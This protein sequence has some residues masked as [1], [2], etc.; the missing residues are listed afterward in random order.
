MPLQLFSHEPQ[1]ACSICKND[2]GIF[3]PQSLTNR[4]ACFNFNPHAEDFNPRTVV[5][6]SAETI[7]ST[8]AV[9]KLTVLEQKFPSL[10]FINANYPVFYGDDALLRRQAGNEIVAS[11]YMCNLNIFNTGL[12]LSPNDL[13]IIAEKFNGLMIFSTAPGSTGYTLWHSQCFMR[14]FNTEPQFLNNAIF[15]W[16]TSTQIFQE[17]RRRQLPVT[18]TSITRRAA[19]A[20]QLSVPPATAT[21]FSGPLCAYADCQAVEPILNSA[22]VYNFFYENSISDAKGSAAIAEANQC[23]PASICSIFPGFKFTEDNANPHCTFI[24]YSAS[25]DLY[26]ETFQGWTKNFA[27]LLVYS[28]TSQRSRLWHATCLEEAVRKHIESRVDNSQP[29]YCLEDDTIIFY[30][31]SP[32]VAISRTLSPPSNYNPFATATVSPISSAPRLMV[33]REV[34]QQKR[35]TLRERRQLGCLYCGEYVSTE[36][37]HISETKHIYSPNAETN[38]AFARF[39]TVYQEYTNIF[40]LYG[41]NDPTKYEFHYA[42]PVNFNACRGNVGID[43]LGDVIESQ[44]IDF[45]K[46]AEPVH[47]IILGILTDAQGSRLVGIHV[48]CSQAH[49]TP[50]SSRRFTQLFRL[51]KKGYS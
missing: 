24:T 1:H 21:L 2:S 49:V 38:N 45:L 40:N 7:R 31:D 43:Q 39:I 35:R 47:D 42:K 36:F 17:K 46:K 16:F 18:P 5:P 34:A 27:H 14:A 30:F 13:E 26:L 37:V 29:S 28:A 23:F 48:R 15:F 8:L 12:E 41:W 9:A 11:Q 6:R 3:I 4:F 33:K 20:P 10:Q 44:L 51:F 32:E 25:H 19:T 50:A 22:R